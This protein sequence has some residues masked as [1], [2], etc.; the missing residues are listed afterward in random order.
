MRKL[1]FGIAAILT[2][3][4]VTSAAW[5]ACH[6]ITPNGSGTKSGSDWNNA[7]SWFSGNC[8][9][10]SGAVRGDTYYIAKGAYSGTTLGK[11]N[12]GTLSITIKSPTAADHCTDTGFVQGTHVGQADIAGGFFITSDRWVVDGQ[13][14]TEVPETGKGTYGIKVHWNGGNGSHRFNLNTGGSNSTFRY[15]ETQGSNAADT[16][17]DEAVKILGF[18]VSGGITDVLV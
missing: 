18:N 2:L 7:C 13:Y 4:L 5:G 15:V 16:G 11:D 6:V 1:L 3:V 14:G 9:M 10:S 8:S 12:S 17:C